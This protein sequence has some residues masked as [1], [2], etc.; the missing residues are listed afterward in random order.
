M[1]DS[2]ELCKLHTATQNYQMLRLHRA[3][4]TSTRCL[5]QAAQVLETDPASL[6]QEQID[7][8][9]KYFRTTKNLRPLV[10]REK[11]ASDL[12]SR[13]LWDEVAK[14][15]VV[16]LDPPK[17]PSKGAL[18]KLINN[19]SSVAELY[20]ARD[21]MLELSQ[22]A[23]YT[24]PHHVNV[25][26]EKSAEMRKFPHALTYLYTQKSLR[27][28][29]DPSNLNMVLFFLYINNRKSLLNA[30]EKAKVATQK[31]RKTDAV[32]DL[33]KASIY[34]K[35]GAE[36]PTELSDA[37][38]TAQAVFIPE[39]HLDKSVGSL[40]KEYAAHRTTYLQFSPIA[41]QCSKALPAVANVQK[42]SQFVQDFKQLQQKL[43]LKDAFSTIQGKS[44][45]RR[46]K[47]PAAEPKEEQA[48]EQSA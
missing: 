33:L 21:L 24:A 39:L 43:Q 6:A 10:Y 31:I 37:I 48:E 44:I 45:F 46:P 32:S 28:K 47:Q 20:A 1:E 19:A 22:Q 40:L 34:I 27:H 7:A 11:N 13:D 26:L 16:P 18:S 14:K 25:F 23:N 9:V 12:L 29:L 35:N 2:N 3:L 5:Q 30:L 42:I 38:S 4:H 17:V 41:L 8:Y 36:V 15:R